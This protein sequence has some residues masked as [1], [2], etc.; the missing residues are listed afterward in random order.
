MVD[1]SIHH[2]VISAFGT[3]RLYNATGML[4]NTIEHPVDITGSRTDRIGALPLYNVIYH[5]IVFRWKF[6]GTGVTGEQY[7]MPPLQPV[8]R[9]RAV[10]RCDRFR[11]AYGQAV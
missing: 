10:R 6:I 2:A 11:F 5:E 8:R 3:I 1:F 7:V 4:L 9:W